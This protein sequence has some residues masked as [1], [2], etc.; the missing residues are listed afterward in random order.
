M[1]IF[2]V[3]ARTTT[4]PGSPPKDFIPLND[5]ANAGGIVT[6]PQDTSG[7]LQALA[8]MAKNNANVPGQPAQ[9]AGGNVP[10]LQSM[11]PQNVPQSVNSG[12]SVPPFA[13][14]VNATGGSNGTNPYG[15]MSS[16]PIPF[17]AMAQM[18]GAQGSMPTNP[19]PQP[20]SNVP[21]PEQL[22]Q[23]VQ[24]IQMLQA[25]GIPQDQWAPVLSALMAAGAGGVAAPQQNFG[26]NQYGGHSD[27]SRDRNGFGDQY[28]MRSPTG[29][30]RRSRSRSPSG[31][32]R[33]RDASPRRRRDSPPY[34]S[35]GGNPYRQRSPDRRRRSDS[36]ADNAL[37][38]S[39]PKNIIY[40]R[41]MPPDHIKGMSYPI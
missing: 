5:N 4:P 19:P 15:G 8:N 12:T 14:A 27:S 17:Q 9:A 30:Y 36:P 1:L 40:D 34:G 28:N 21:S 6:Q 18:Q 24:I 33:R 13:Q 31:Y 37:P 29:R 38:P 3:G 2:F 23:Q 26:Q 7:I 20:Q 10:N 16:V 35:R 25:Q 22:Q 41:S 11:Y 32:D 39:G